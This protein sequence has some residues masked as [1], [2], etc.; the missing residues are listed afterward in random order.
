VDAVFFFENQFEWGRCWTVIVCHWSI[1]GAS[2]LMRVSRNKYKAYLECRIGIVK[3]SGMECLTSNPM[4]ENRRND[5]LHGAQEK[6]RNQIRMINTKKF[7]EE[8]GPHVR[9]SP[10][11]L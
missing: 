3:N 9:N 7:F 11:F 2:D 8:V 6:R 5:R 1:G 10:K 4:L